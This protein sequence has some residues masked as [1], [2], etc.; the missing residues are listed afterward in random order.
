MIAID[1]AVRIIKEQAPFTEYERLPLTKA[2]LRVLAEDIFAREPAPRFT[3][4]AM[5]G[6]AVRW[7]DLQTLPANL[8]IIGESRA[9][10]PFKGEVKSGEAVRIS[11]GALMPDGADTVIPVEDTEETD[12]EAIILK[13]GKKAANVR[14]EGEEIKAGD[15]LVS[16]GSRIY[17]EHLAVLAS[18]GI[19][20]VKIFKAPRVVLLTT[21]AEVKRFD[22]TPEYFQIRDSNSPTLAAAITLA[23][24]ELISTDHLPDDLNL[25]IDALKEAA[26]KADVLILSGGVS[27]GRHDHVKSAAEKAGFS[28]IFWKINQKPGK[29]FYFAK[30]DKTL[31]FGLPGNPVSAFMGFVHYIFP[32]LRFM[33][34]DS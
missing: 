9:G 3:N 32:L 27:M 19:S 30:K 29:P 11:T 28:P 25:T 22:E 16:S 23:G 12:G 24:A 34:G 6:F 2:L 20:E 8:S 33:E 1:E 7:E 5:D 14:Y 13:A 17:P 18:Q 21:G 15:L 10:V 26:Q 31:L 4:S